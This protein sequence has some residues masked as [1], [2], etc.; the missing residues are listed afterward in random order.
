MIEK[1]S[2]IIGRSLEVDITINHELLSRE[3]LRIKLKGETI[4]LEE[5]G[6][7]NGS[8]VNGEKISAKKEKI[9]TSNSPIFL[10]N[11]IGPSIKVEMIFVNSEIE[12]KRIKEVNE[13]V[14]LV[15]LNPL[16]DQLKKESNVIIMR[17]ESDSAKAIVTRGSQASSSFQKVA[18]G[19]GLDDWGVPPKTY[20][21]NQPSKIKLAENKNS[22]ID[23]GSDL[24]SQMK[25]MLNAEAEN[26]IQNAKSIAEKT[27]H[28]A[29]NKAKASLDSAKK[30]AEDIRIKIQREKEVKLKLLYKEI[31]ELKKE[32]EEKITHL[33][34]SAQD[35]SLQIEKISKVEAEKTRQSATKF[36]NDLM[37]KSKEIISAST[38]RAD[39]LVQ[40]KMTQ[41]KQDEEL[42]ILN[43]KILNE[44]YQDLKLK[45][46]SL[47]KLE[48]DARVSYE[49]LKKNIERDEGRIDAERS[50][51]EEL[52]SELIVT[53]RECNQQ[54]AELKSEERNAKNRMETELIE[55]KLKVTQAL[56]DAQQ[57]QIKKETLLA[58]INF[59]MLEKERHEQLV[60]DTDSDYQEKLQQIEIL[61]SK[62]ALSEKNL[63]QSQNEIQLIQSNI[64][65]Q[66]LEIIKALDNL[67]AEEIRM[68]E[69]HKSTE[70]F[71]FETAENIKKENLL[72]Q[73]LK[74][75][76]HKELEADKLLHEKK[77][78]LLTQELETF[79]LDLDNKRMLLL[80]ELESESQISKK[81]LKAEVQKTKLLCEKEIKEILEQRSQAII[82][83]NAA[84]IESAT[85]IQKAKDE[86]NQFI[87]SI[88]IEKERIK[89]EAN[90]E[91]TREKEKLR[92]II[93][94]AKK[95]CQDSAKYLLVEINQIENDKNFLQKE[96][97][98]LAVSR[99]K[100]MTEIDLEI[101]NKMKDARLNAKRLDEEA[102]LEI[103]KQKTV[104]DELKQDEILNIKL[105]KEAAIKEIYGKKSE[106]AKVVSTA[107]DTVV[108]SE[109]KKY[110]Y[111]RIN[112]FFIDEF[113]QNLSTIV[114]ETL[115]DRY[116]P[117]KQ[118]LES[119]KLEASNSYKK[120]VALNKILKKVGRW[121]LF[122]VTGSAV[123]YVYNLPEFQP[124]KKE[125]FEIIESLISSYFSN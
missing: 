105:M 95:E 31:E 121:T 63:A 67:R 88:K 110:K 27:I 35:K 49:L 34:Q 6:S 46:D 68:S 111:K 102:A 9:Y 64:E 47:K 96:I 54:L 66:Q 10:G 104:L 21:K 17:K 82:N 55:Q 80:E 13:E 58:E 73:N 76:F 114:L 50:S 53:K 112:D 97:D 98:D 1:P 18:N 92:Q 38:R 117:D 91:L 61:K 23:N 4:F 109:L 85:L 120:T 40:E 45:V 87:Q 79:K 15:R 89:A 22:E 12:T 119:A 78:I 116:S 28:E 123:L 113:S 62:E 25:S 84:K 71:A 7:R 81:N 57:G 5:L 36:A 52:R 86:F 29:Q 44:N 26:K 65:S 107:V 103:Q 37:S 77:K 118:K 74:L 59:L 108:L 100:R 8:W 48:A 19:R 75:D 14:T 72:I 3:H 39:D 33:L 125:I 56:A 30:E 99:D 16:I 69:L 24:I 90:S 51:L 94:A 83:T 93:N 43:S 2:F 11:L 122:I 42:L 20:P 101:N 41:F 115:M 60:R 124:I 106:R 32:N 70:V